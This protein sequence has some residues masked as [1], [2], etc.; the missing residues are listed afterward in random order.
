MIKYI[1]GNILDAPENIIVH[2]VNCKGVMGAGLAKQLVR[3]YPLILGPYKQM[4]NT[5]GEGCLGEAQLI[6]VSA[7][8][9]K[10]NHKFVANLFGQNNYGRIPDIVYTDY[11]AFGKALNQ[12]KQFAIEH[13]FSVAIPYGIGCGLAN[14]NWGIIEPIIRRTFSETNINVSIYKY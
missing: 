10:S 3:E 12:I 11:I 7:L 2:Q 14:G 6:Q 5:K 8:P 4:C 13:N 9:P 1:N